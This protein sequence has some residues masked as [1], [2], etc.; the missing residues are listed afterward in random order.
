[1]SRTILEISKLIF[2]NILYIDK[3][4]MYTKLS[5]EHI[6]IF[7]GG[8]KIEI[9]E[10][11]KSLGDLNRLRIL[12]ILKT[13]KKACNCDLE[14]VLE[15]NQ[16]NASRHITKLK[17]EKLINYEKNGKWTYY[18]INQE[19]IEKYPFIE[20]VLNSLVEEVFFYDSQ[21]FSLFKEKK[22]KCVINL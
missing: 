5:H 1:M 20:E 17:K 14:E 8:R 6:I 4:I 2:R 11:L 12:N 3:K 18:S 13:F 22:D 19:V 21:K 10:I 7:N 15:L 16:S 9:V